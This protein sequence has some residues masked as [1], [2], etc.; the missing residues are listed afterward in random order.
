MAARYGLGFALIGSQILIAGAV[1]AGPARAD[2][3]SFL[4]HLHAAGIHDVDGGDA[5]LLEVG[6][7]ICNQLWYGASPEELEALA[8]QRSDTR[9]GG[10]GLNTA[11]ADALVGFAQADLCPNQ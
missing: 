2:A 4:A 5:A 9:L 10:Q 6:Q 7:K 11:Q 1:W 8:L 3:D